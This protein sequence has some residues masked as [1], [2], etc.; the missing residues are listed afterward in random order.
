MKYRTLLLALCLSLCTSARAQNITGRVI[1]SLTNTPIPFA[2][3]YLDGTSIGEVT[4]DDGTF[5]LKG[6]RLPATL[7]VSHL[8][9][10]TLN[11]NLT[12]AGE[13]GDLIISPSKNLIS[14]IEVKDGNLRGKTL[15]EFTGLLL[16]TDEW[17]QGASFQNDEVL[18]F[19]RDYTERTMK[20]TSEKMRERLKKRNRPG[21]SWSEDGT[22]YTFSKPDNLI[23]KSRGILKIRLPHLGYTVSMDLNIFLSEY[24]SRYT[25]YLG[26]FF[27][28]ADKKETDSHL[29]NRRRAYYGSSMHFARA[30]LSDSLEQNG[31]QVYAVGKGQNGKAEQLAE[32]DLTR[33]LV[34]GENGINH[35]VGLDGREFAILY[36][37]DGRSRPLA[38]GKWR[39]GQP[40]Q[41]RI[42]V[43][44]NKC[45][46]LDSGV[47]G[48][49]NLIFN[50]NMGVRKLAWSLPAD[51][52]LRE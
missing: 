39:R 37:A 45:L 13:L 9:Y 18:E 41:S 10:Q 32:A 48:D 46:V 2:T 21:I 28:E 36:Y 5:S 6:G 8:A 14:E 3:V 4:G 15:A 30:L 27:F 40:I 12:T 29:R 20:V 42:I 44:A 22:S 17:A 50:G 49:T 38:K 26:T 23:A 52:V 35:L 7:V 19:D 51:Y 11:L 33:F 34:R 16:G 1:D 25:S 43:R 47:F 24:K 31:F